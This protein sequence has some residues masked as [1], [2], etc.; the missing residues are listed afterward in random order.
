MTLNDAD[1][2]RDHQNLLDYG[3]EKLE[4]VNLNDIVI[5]PDNLPTVSSDGAKINI[6]LNKNLIVKTEKEEIKYTV[7]LPSYITHDVKSGDKIGELTIKAGDREEKIDIIAENSVKIKNTV[8][9][10][11]NRR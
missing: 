5:L 6:K 3:F 11:F 9:P 1:D 7:D 2:W 10:F 4:S 8:K